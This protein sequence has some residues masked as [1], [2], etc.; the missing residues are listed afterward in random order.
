MIVILTKSM[1]HWKTPESI[2][3]I[4]K[5]RNGQIKR[6]YC[7]IQL[8]LS[9]HIWFLVEFEQAKMDCK[10]MRL[11]CCL[12]LMNWMKI[13]HLNYPN[14]AATKNETTK[15]TTKL[16]RK[17]SINVDYILICYK[18]NW[19]ENCVAINDKIIFSKFTFSTQKPIWWP[20][21]KKW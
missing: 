14:W 13:I 21:D 4:A 2:K 19:V 18:F 15:W 5:I 11:S 17:E 20:Y 6:N 8:F 12:N 16:T 10:A 3:I 1:K 7:F 9:L